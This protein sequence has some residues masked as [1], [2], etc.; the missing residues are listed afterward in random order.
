MNS[1]GI[2]YLHCNVLEWD[3]SLAHFG[4]PHIRLWAEEIITS[5]LGEYKISIS[6]AGD[7][8][9]TKPGEEC[10]SLELVRDLHDYDIEDSVEA[11]ISTS[12]R[13]LLALKDSLFVTSENENFKITVTLQIPISKLEK[14]QLTNNGIMFLSDGDKKLPFEGMEM[15]IHD[16]S[17]QVSSQPKAMGQ[18]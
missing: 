14:T 17:F 8:L 9:N 7:N 4:E 13:Y 18:R 16:I 10:G 5:M 3:Y 11:H 2:F 1:Y 6:I 12:E 15:K